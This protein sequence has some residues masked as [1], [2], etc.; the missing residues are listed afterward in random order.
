MSHEHHTLND[1]HDRLTR[2]CDAAIKAVD[3]HP[4]CPEDLK[5]IIMI[6]D[7]HQGG[8]GA[9]GYEGPGELLINLYEHTKAMFEAHDIPFDVI[10]PG[11]MN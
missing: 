9:H 3:A 5:F 6:D 11:N 8:I 7:G 4:E 1:P 2:L 10:I